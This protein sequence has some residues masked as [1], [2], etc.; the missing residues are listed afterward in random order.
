MNDEAL[1]FYSTVDICD[2]NLKKKTHKCNILLF[3]FD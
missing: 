1:D 2:R 3:L